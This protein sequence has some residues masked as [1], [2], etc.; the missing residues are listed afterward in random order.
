MRDEY[1]RRSTGRTA[2]Q[3]GLWRAI[4]VSGC[5]VAGA[6]ILPST[7]SALAPGRGYELVSP[8]DKA[9]ASASPY[10]ISADGSRV[11]M[12]SGGGFAGAPA[13]DGIFNSYLV[14]RSPGGWLTAA[15]SFPAAT[16]FTPGKRADA[17]KD[18]SR[19]LMMAATYEQSQHASTAFYLRDADG[20]L[21]VASPTIVDRLN[22]DS[23]DNFVNYVGAAADFSSFVFSTVPTNPVLDTDVV[24]P[25]TLFNLYEVTG[26]GTST[27]AVRRVD[28]DTNGTIPGPACG[29]QA[30]GARS[31][32][33]VVSDDGQK[34]FF[35]GRRPP[36]PTSCAAASRGPLKVFARIGGTTTAE[37]SASQ[38]SRVA[39]PAAVPPVTACAPPATS[40]A[41][42]RTAADVQYQGASTDGGS[43]FFSTNQQLT[44]SDTDATE[45]L[46]EYRFSPGAG[47]PTL[48]Q[49]SAGAGSSATPG[50]GALFQGVVRTSDDGRRAY[51][52][53]QGKLTSDPNG[54]GE[55]AV[56]GQNNL[57][58]F[59]RTA[60]HP[61][62]RTRFVA[63]LDAGDSMLWGSDA[64]R[65]AQLASADGSILV[66]Q[67][68]AQLTDDDTDSAADI[69]R[70]DAQ[71]SSTVRVSRGKDGFAQDGNTAGQAAN[72]R[73]PGGAGGQ[74]PRAQWATNVSED[75][76][77]IVFQT[78]EAL[79]SDD[80]NDGLDVYE[81]HDG[82]VDMVT[83]GKERNP[84]FGIYSI[85]P[86]GGSIVFASTNRLLGQ[87]VDSA[88]DA[89]VARLGGGFPPP[90]SEPDSSCAGDVC[91]GDTALPP[92]SGESLSERFA[93]PGNLVPAPSVP[94]SKLSVA[95]AKT[96]RGSTAQ[97][98]VQVSGKGKIRITGAGLVGSVKSVS[99]AG[100]YRVPVRLS[101]R[102]RATLKRKG[103]VKVRV[104]VRFAP[105]SGVPSTAAASVTFKAKAAKKAAKKARKASSRAVPHV[106]V[107]SSD[108]RKGQ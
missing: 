56:A 85:T 70:Y 12:D 6:A 34:I 100:S 102:A 84:K 66:F 76:S 99:T 4:G 98:R 92:V 47:Q 104:T 90:E 2:W 103:Q 60:A 51:F 101:K 38:C 41:A 23:I 105:E 54:A 15:Q 58:L 14:T 5:L 65:Q 29:R 48:T 10:A 62:G 68:V 97:A 16:Y 20:S 25:A 39:N 17:T 63:P 35:S 27:P 1:T 13:Q 19:T 32:L 87:D 18:L 73:E 49:V 71:T 96:V 108:A 82:A 26:V 7:A 28:L 74:S 33:N 44:S 93:G 106:D 91:Q 95:A 9:G 52:V 78:A 53:A 22:P 21:T 79:Q 3:R 24:A 40:P 55:T 57:Y 64:G 75:G 77:R 89:Y 67:S 11:L 107:P 72:I 50:S 37:I 69:F 80:T 83:D 31:S 81:W 43:V 45:D 94:A 30:G 59:E 8:P 86:D 61:E 36:V 88:S 46:Y 42:A